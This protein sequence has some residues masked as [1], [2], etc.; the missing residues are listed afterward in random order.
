LQL[1]HFVLVG[2]IKC[3]NI[4]QKRARVG[5]TLESYTIS[6]SSYIIRV[7]FHR[8][9]KKHSWK[10][11]H[12]KR[13]WYYMPSREILVVD[14][15]T[16]QHT[17]YMWWVTLYFCAASSEFNQMGHFFVVVAVVGWYSIGDWS[18]P[19]GRAAA[20][21]RLLNEPTDFLSLICCCH[22]IAFFS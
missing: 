16:G 8:D 22:S 20:G 12:T 19:G 9:K 11:A 15:Y 18:S 5:Y 21:P 13:P 10:M 4:S 14:K 7:W 2:Q 6:P 3:L 1:N 17:R